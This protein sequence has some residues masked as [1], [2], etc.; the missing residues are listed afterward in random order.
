ML[1]V[2]SDMELKLSANLPGVLLATRRRV[3]SRG[4]SKAQ[5]SIKFSKLTTH[6]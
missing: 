3:L 4:K 2:A 5:T 1:S 6:G